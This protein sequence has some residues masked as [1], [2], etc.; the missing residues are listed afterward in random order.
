MADDSAPLRYPHV[1]RANG[2]LW[3]DNERRLADAGHCA[4]DEKLD[5]IALL[6]IDFLRGRLKP[7]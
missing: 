2:Q 4:L 5:A 1:S 6:M 3:R 7:E